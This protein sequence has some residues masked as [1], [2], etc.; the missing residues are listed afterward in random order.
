MQL[1]ALYDALCSSVPEQGGK[2]FS[3]VDKMAQLVKTTVGQTIGFCGL[4]AAF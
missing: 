1:L 2:S 4:P 3:G